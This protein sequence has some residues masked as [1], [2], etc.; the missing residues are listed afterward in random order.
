MKSHLAPFARRLVIG[1]TAAI[2]LT[3]LPRVA[4]ACTCIGGRSFD[5]VA[6]SMPVVVVGLVTAQK[7]LIPE[8]INWPAIVQAIEVEIAWVAKGDVH[9]PRVTVWD[10]LAMTSCGGAFSRTP[11]GTWV[12]LAL[13][14]VESVRGLNSQ[15][16]I[17]VMGF[18][19]PD[20]DLILSGGCS[21][22]SVSFRTGA[23]RESY[24]GRRYR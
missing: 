8:T 12:A 11:V 22:S 17:A 14:H 9:G 21:Q 6:S 5:E 19:A 7:A 18:S 1:L 23:E 13:N 24:I 20:H 15:V 2:A 16:D 4:E 10:R 3:C